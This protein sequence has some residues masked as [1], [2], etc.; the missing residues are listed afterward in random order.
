[1]I[2]VASDEVID[3]GELP[4][5]DI[6]NPEEIVQFIRAWIEW[7]YGRNVIGLENIKPSQNFEGFQ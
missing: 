1:M 2:V 4:L 3:T 5:L 7:C 6:K